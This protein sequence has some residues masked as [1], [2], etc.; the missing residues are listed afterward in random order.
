MTNSFLTITSYETQAEG[1]Q[2]LRCYTM[3]NNYLLIL[4]EFWQMVLQQ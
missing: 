2:P 3:L 1:L 4:A